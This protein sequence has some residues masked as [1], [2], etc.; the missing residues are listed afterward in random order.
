[1]SPTN[2]R[3]AAPSRQRIHC[4]IRESDGRNSIPDPGM[5]L[6]NIRFWVQSPKYSLLR[7]FDS[8]AHIPNRL[9][10]RNQKDTRSAA[11]SR[12]RM[13][14][15]MRESHGRNSIPDPGMRMSLLN[16]RFW[17]PS[18][19]YSLLRSFD[20][21]AHIPNHLRS[22]NQKDTRSAAPSRQRM[23]CPMRESHG[24][25]SIPD[26]AM[27]LSLLNSPAHIPNHL[28]TPN[29]KDRRSEAL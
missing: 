9:R 27:R 11:P 29:Q 2:M 23:H 25:N 6:L 8:H 7:S 21:H 22:P 20:S 5:S 17:V 24:R 4:L 18:P 12:Q 19:K 15:L 28:R 26:P 10:S 13:H 16:I 3:S 1:M 14:R